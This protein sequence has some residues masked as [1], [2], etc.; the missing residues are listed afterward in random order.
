MANIFAQNDGMPVCRSPVNAFWLKSLEWFDSPA[1]RLHNRTVVRQLEMQKL[2]G[3]LAFAK[4][5][6]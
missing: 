3:A 2:H 5:V 1:C 6:I 4:R